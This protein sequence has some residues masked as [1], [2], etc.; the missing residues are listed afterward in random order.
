MDHFVA[1]AQKGFG[2]YLECADKLPHL[3]CARGSPSLG[4]P[5]EGKR[6]HHLKENLRKAV[7]LLE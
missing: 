1:V 4:H 7:V 2:C 5:T 3:L 6:P